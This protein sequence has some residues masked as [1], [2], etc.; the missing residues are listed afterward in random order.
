[1]KK[2][3]GVVLIIVALVCAYIGIT[4][5]AGSTDSVNI[6]GLELSATDESQA[7]QGMLYLGVALVSL[8]G[9]V[10]LVGKSS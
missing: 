5:M 3:I 8:I 7:S 2:I 9:G 4:Q 1:M 6:L 10:F